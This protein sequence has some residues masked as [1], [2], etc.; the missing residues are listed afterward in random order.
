M[1]CTKVT[2]TVTVERHTK[3]VTEQQCTTKL[4]SGTVKFTSTGTPVTAVLSRAGIV[5]ATGIAVH[6]HLTLHPRRALRAGRYTLTLTSGHRR[7]RK[8]TREELTI[9]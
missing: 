7:G 1:I 6:T 9:S 3:F 2:K 4:V 8:T 5:Y